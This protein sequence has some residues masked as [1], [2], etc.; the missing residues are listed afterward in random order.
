M[1]AKGSLKF[2]DLLRLIFL[3]IEIA[4]FCHSCERA[5]CQKKLININIDVSKIMKRGHV[6][7]HYNNET[8]HLSILLFMIDKIHCLF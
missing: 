4:L 7:P 2:E 1:V 3:M 8:L 6:K 5:C